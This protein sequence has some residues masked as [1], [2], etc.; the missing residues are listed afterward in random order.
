MILVFVCPLPPTN[1]PQH[2]TIS[3]TYDGEMKKATFCWLGVGLF[4]V[5][6]QKL[7]G[8][9]KKWGVSPSRIFFCEKS[10]LL[11]PTSSNKRIKQINGCVKYFWT[12]VG[13]IIETQ[14]KLIISR[15]PH[16]D[17]DVCAYLYVNILPDI[18]KVIE[19]QVNNNI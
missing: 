18:N 10:K 3:W 13:K 7:V 2:Q 15:R 12:D 9:K 17:D 11:C 4:F 5:G 1:I 16:F 8:K 19:T 14:I 6:G